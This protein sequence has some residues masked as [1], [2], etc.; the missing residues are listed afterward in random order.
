ML[1]GKC[2]MN[3]ASEGERVFGSAYAAH[4]DRLYRDKD[5]AGEC[6]FLETI[7]QKFGHKKTA[8]ILD[9]GCGTGSHALLL[10]RRGYEVTGVD[11]STD[12]LAIARQRAA[13]CELKVDFQAGDIRR[14]DLG[15]SFDAVISMFAVISYQT[16]NT[17][18]CAALQTV[19]RH[20]KP[21]G[22]FVFDCWFGPTVLAERPE[23][24]QRLIEENGERLLR[25]VTPV[26]DSTN[27][28]VSVTYQLLRIRDDRLLEDVTEVHCMRFLFP[29]EIRYFLE[30]NGFK[31]INLCPFLDLTR[32]PEEGD[33]NIVVIASGC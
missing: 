21:G 8:S 12:M 18:L 7:F 27:Q 22:L 17:D 5:Y 3:V 1:F 23:S 2:A 28:T 33:W 26:L 30:T 20:L 31:M 6:D 13:E 32:P 14:L 11:R 9:L 10:T 24:R 15:Q 4:Y 19:R 16:R 25:F 29:Q